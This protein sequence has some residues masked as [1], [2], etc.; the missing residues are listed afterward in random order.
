MIINDMR[1]TSSDQFIESVEVELERRWHGH[2]WS[3]GSRQVKR[4]DE[5]LFEGRSWSA[6][7]SEVG[8]L[9]LRLPRMRLSAF[10]SK[11][12]YLSIYFSQPTWL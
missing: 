3:M 9:I 1:G 2:I 12:K 4:W 6:K 8:I 10:L 5:Q 7:E 11:Q